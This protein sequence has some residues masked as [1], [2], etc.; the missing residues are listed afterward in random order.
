[1]A[2]KNSLKIQMKKAFPSFAGR[3]L[4]SGPRPKSAQPASRARLASLSPAQRRAAPGLPPR[5]CPRRAARPTAAELARRVAAMRRRRRRVS[6]PACAR[7]HA[8]AYFCW[9]RCARLH[10]PALP[11]LSA[12][13][14][15]TH[16]PPRR[17]TA[18]AGQIRRFSSTSA[19]NRAPAAPPRSP[20]RGA[21]ACANCRA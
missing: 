6:Q 10:S 14:E 12:G 8:P 9:S 5:A 20:A 19:S 4:T 15:L 13:A 21:R 3:R 1:M 2:F 16:S 17:A 11:L 7:V 18:P